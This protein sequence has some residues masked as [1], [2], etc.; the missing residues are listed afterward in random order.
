MACLALLLTGSH[1]IDG[2]GGEGFLGG[3]A[4]GHVALRVIVGGLLIPVAHIT[5]MVDLV[6]GFKF[7]FLPGVGGDVVAAHVDGEPQWLT[8]HPC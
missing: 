5:G 3:F 4:L 6:E 1:E 2:A 8:G 7:Q